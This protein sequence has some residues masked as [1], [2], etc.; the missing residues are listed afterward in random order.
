MPLPKSYT[1][2]LVA[3]LLS[4]GCK[5]NY[6]PLVI[7]NPP[8][9]LVV[10]GFLN[11]SINDT[12]YIKLSRT[13]K[14]SEGVVNSAELNAVLSIEDESGNILYTSSENGGGSYIFPGISLDPD[15]HYKLRIHT[16]NGQEYLSDILSGAT[17]PPIDSIGFDKTGKGVD[18][19]VNTHD[20]Q[21]KTLYY[22]WEYNETFQYHATYYSGLIFPGDGSYQFRQ[23]DQQIYE[24]W[25]SEPST[26]LLLA[27]SANLER[28]IIY[29][30]ILRHVDQDA[31]EL[32]LKYFI[33]VKQY[34]LTKGAYE[35]LQNLKKLTENAGGLF[36]VQPSELGGNI[37]NVTNPG[38]DALGY[39]TVATSQ[40]SEIYFTNAQVQPW[41][42]KL[43]C[44]IWEIKPNQIPNHTSPDEIIGLGLDGGPYNLKGLYVTTRECGDCQVVGGITTRPDFWQ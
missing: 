38:E 14:L 9:L 22:R 8:S 24:C 10:D 27:S 17:T 19:H 41:N 28:D 30:R 29:K 39:I 16:N 35:Y 12:T 44:S 26:Q 33:K 15:Q 13:N 40:T 1:L 36:D 43:D 31:V 18:I 4:V 7:S 5:Q 25:K 21:N 3:F 20:D 37:H 2:P 23:P 42:Y 6:L 32:S 11:N 34:A